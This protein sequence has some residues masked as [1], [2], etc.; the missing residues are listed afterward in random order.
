M[1]SSWDRRIGDVPAASDMNSS[2]RVVGYE[3]INLVAPLGQ[4]T[5]VTS[6]LPPL[7]RSRA[8]PYAQ[9]F[10]SR[11]S[12]GA[13]SFFLFA[14]LFQFCHPDPERNERK[15]KGRD[16]QFSA[17]FT[18]S[19]SC[20]KALEWPMTLL[21]DR[22]ESVRRK[23]EPSLP[24]FGQK[25]K[26]EREKRKITL[27]QISLST[28]IGIRMLQALEEDKFNQLPGGIFNKGFVRAYSRFLGL[29]EDQIIAD[30]LQAS[31]DALPASTEPATHGEGSR[32][33]AAQESETRENQ[34]KVNHL[35]AGADPPPRQV[36]WGMFAGALLVVALALSFWSHRRRE[37]MQQADRPTPVTAETHA[38][39][40]VSG[41]DLPTTSA[42]PTSSPSGPSAPSGVPMISPDVAP[43]SPAATPGEFTVVIQA[44]EESSTT[45][46]ADGTTISS[47]LLP[48][49]SA[50][51][52]P[53]PN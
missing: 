46:T 43:A 4:R 50:P 42:P 35:E 51:S 11:A 37:H 49:A 9:F 21:L 48:P 13:K 3:I 24:S 41:S 39:G 23:R 33:N 14:I 44:R 16:L 10:L 18:S 19:A 1:V 22:V 30:Y 47:E 25:L 34:E 52:S 8:N 2:V 29:D 26:L 38:S 15:P 5:E 40:P 28:K 7:L 53:T 12:E 36:P 32:E 6:T 17:R 31:G 27:E 45:I 20:R